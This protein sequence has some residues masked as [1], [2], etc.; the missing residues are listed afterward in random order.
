MGDWLLRVIKGALIGVGAI[1]PGISGGVLS[2]VLG[3]YRPLMAFLAHPVKTFQRHAAF[4][5]PVVLGWAVGVILLARVV[6]WLFQTYPTPAI[7]LFIGLVVGT[8]PSL[9]KEAGQEGRPKGAWAALVAGGVLMGSW[10]YF[11]SRSGGTQV[12]PNIAWWLL[13]GV[14]W[15]VGLIV[16]GLSSSSFFIFFGLYQPM[17]AAIGHLDF[18]VIIPMGIGLVLSIVLLA[19]GMNWLLKRAYPYVMHAIFGIVIA[20]T[21][22]I[23]PLGEPATAGQI[24]IYVVCFAAGCGIAFTMDWMSNKFK[25][26]GKMK[27]D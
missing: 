14:L 7:W 27:D 13:C 10:L 16:P 1:L 12:T 23:L 25:K 24:A 26:D 15:G 19:R 11:L 22:A 6:D 9:F 20:S 3:I 5:L 2:V 8:C 4:L 17:T 21:L 18:S